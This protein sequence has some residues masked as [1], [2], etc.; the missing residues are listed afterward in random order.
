MAKSKNFFGIRSGSTKSHTY[1]TYRGWQITK[2][3]VEHVSNPQSA[4]QMAQRLKLVGVANAAAQLKGLVDHSFQGITYGWQS[5]Q[6][7]RRRNLSKPNLSISG[8]VPKG[9]A[10]CG[11]ANYIV[12]TG[13]LSE[14]L[15]DTTA[16]VPTT[17]ANYLMRMQLTSVDYTPTDLLEQVDQEND[18]SIKATEKNMNILANMFGIEPGQQLTLLL[19]AIN[20]EKSVIDVE[21]ETQTRNYFRSKFFVV[22][23]ITDY[24]DEN[25]MKGWRVKQQADNTL[26]YEGGN[27]IFETTNSDAYIK[28]SFVLSPSSNYTAFLD[29]SAIIS[30]AALIVSQKVNGTYKRSLA[31]LE[32]TQLGLHYAWA[33]SLALETYL[34]DGGTSDLYLNAGNESTGIT[35]I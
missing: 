28:P 23:V 4:G 10:D 16:M 13:E 2:D 14:P 8:Y 7:F 34:K 24:T 29:A 17:D 32:P 27:L 9:A 5:V 12:S 26:A 35:N 25:F 18:N 15:H 21:T 11:L 19:Q 30:A 3:R 33:Y 22:R 1:Q 31:R 20:T 6:E